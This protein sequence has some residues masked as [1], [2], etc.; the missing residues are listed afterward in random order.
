[1]GVYH[2]R[3]TKSVARDMPLETSSVKWK[4]DFGGMTRV[5]KGVKKASSDEASPEARCTFGAP[6]T[7]LFLIGLRPRRARLRFTK[8]NK[9][10]TG[11]A[12]TPEK[13]QPG[14]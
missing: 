5:S 9:H 2:V 10:R 1:M 8:R 4:S 3:V 6:L 12:V 14:P 11:V 7:W 13:S